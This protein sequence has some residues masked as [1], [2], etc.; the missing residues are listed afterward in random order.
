MAWSP[1]HYLAVLAALKQNLRINKRSRH[2]SRGESI[3][4][5]LR[6]HQRFDEEGPVRDARGTCL[7]SLNPSTWWPRNIR[8]P[9]GVEHD[10][11]R[12][13]PRRWRR[14]R[15]RGMPEAQTAEKFRFPGFG[16]LHSLNHVGSTA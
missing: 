8:F 1:T 11:R 4:E 7:N 12:W 9:D 16:R 6:R 3:H 14:G 10:S 13:F 5:A 15:E 2:I